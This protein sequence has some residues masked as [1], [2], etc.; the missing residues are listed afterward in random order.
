MTMVCVTWIC[1]TN[2]YAFCEILVYVHVLVC[3][4][5]VCVHWPICVTQVCI[6]CGV[7]VDTCVH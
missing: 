2:L 6:H 1:D 3:V 7:C 4:T 5:Q